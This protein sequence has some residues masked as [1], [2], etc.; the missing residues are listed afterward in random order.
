MNLVMVSSNGVT[1]LCLAAELGC[2]VGLLCQSPSGSVVFCIVGLLF[3]S[4]KSDCFVKLL[5]QTHIKLTFCTV[6]LLCQ[7]TLSSCLSCWR[8]WPLRLSAVSGYGV[9]Q[10]CQAV[11]SC[12]CFR[13]LCQATLWGCYVRKLCQ[14]AVSGSSVRLLRQATVSGCFVMKFGQAAL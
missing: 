8:I 6:R 7:A 5:R 1:M 9:R 10:L 12:W 3:Y 4:A 13:Q 14:A 11:S 2:C